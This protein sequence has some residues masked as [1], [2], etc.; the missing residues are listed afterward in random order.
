MSRVFGPKIAD[1][2]SIGTPC[3]ICGRQ[4]VTGDLTTLVPI[5]PADDENQAKRAAGRA[6]TS[7]A[8]EVHANCENALGAKP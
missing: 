6:Y 4:F 5:G 7:E 2:P 8:R 3:P 1:H